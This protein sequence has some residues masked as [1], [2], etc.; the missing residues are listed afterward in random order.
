MLSN[1]DDTRFFLPYNPNMNRLFSSVMIMLS[2]NLSFAKPLTFQETLI[3]ADEGVKSA[4]YDLGVMYS[5]GW[6]VVENTE[7]A[8]RW[9]RQASA[10]GSFLARY[11][12]GLIYSNS[13]RINV[14]YMQA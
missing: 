2:V 4:M 6:G 8:I 7:E 13:D 1:S 3:S 10:Q 9:F 12:L 5:N 14:S 11:E